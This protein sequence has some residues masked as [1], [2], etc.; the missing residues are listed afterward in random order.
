[1]NSVTAEHG[2]THWITRARQHTHGGKWR[3]NSEKTARF[4][5]NERARTVPV[6]ARGDSR[7]A[8]AELRA[9]RA[10]FSSAT[11]SNRRGAT[12][13]QQ[14]KPMK[15][16]VMRRAAGGREPRPQL[17]PLQARRVCFSRPPRWHRAERADSGVPATTAG[18]RD[19]QGRGAIGGGP[20]E[21]PPPEAL[22]KISLLPG[23]H[24]TPP[25]AK[26]TR[27][28]RRR[29][30]VWGSEVR[31]SP[32]AGDAKQYETL[33]GEGLASP[34]SGGGPELHA[35]RGTLCTET[36][37]CDPTV[38]AADEGQPSP[39]PVSRRPQCEA[40]VGERLAEKEAA[41]AAVGG[42]G[43]RAAC[44]GGGRWRCGY[45]ATSFERISYVALA[46]PH[47]LGL[48]SSMAYLS[49]SR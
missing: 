13:P 29:T 8:I 48:V 1:M 45:A 38:T 26:P 44:G 41:K 12:P 42:G 37:R 28:H 23:A 18:Q 21:D 49:F 32:C 10:A 11:K 9:C 30:S 19:P 16:A 2:H 27:A 17:P 3:A 25:L 47:L 24:P 34:G 22:W 46:E 35:K 4:T 6:C 7:Q 39:E 5:V 36:S 20:A 33:P 43:G 15:A 14:T 31:D 40:A